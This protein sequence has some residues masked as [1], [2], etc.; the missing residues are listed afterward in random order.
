MVQQPAKNFQ[1][2]SNKIFEITD[3]P[4]E[5]NMMICYEAGISENDYGGITTNVPP[6]VSIKLKSIKTST[7]LDI[8]LEYSEIISLYNHIKS[9]KNGKQ[10]IVLNTFN[11]QVNKKLTVSVNTVKNIFYLLIIEDPKNPTPSA[12]ITLNPE[13]L[14]TFTTI[15]F[16][17]GNNWIQNTLSMNT[18]LSNHRIILELNN[19]NSNYIKTTLNKNVMNSKTPESTLK[20]EPISRVVLPNYEQTLD[21]FNYNSYLENEHV[22]EDVHEEEVTPEKKLLDSFYKFDKEEILK[23]TLK[24][25]LETVEDNNKQKEI[26]E[27]SIIFDTPSKEYVKP[28]QTTSS[29]RPFFN[30]FIEWD[31]E[32]LYKWLSAFSVVN[33][34]SKDLTFLPLEL[35]LTS[36]I[37]KDSFDEIKNSKDY[38]YFQYN[39][40]NN[41]KSGIIKYINEKDTNFNTRY[42]RFEF[43]DVN[44]ITDKNDNIHIWNFI[45]DITLLNVMYRYFLNSFKKLNIKQSSE[46][47]F[48]I[49]LA[50][51]FSTL[52]SIP[53]IKLVD[54]N[55]LPELLKDVSNLYSEV[56]VKGVFENL[57]NIFSNASMGGKFN[58]DFEGIYNYLDKFIETVGNAEITN[59][60]E[61]EIHN[62]E[63]IK[64]QFKT[65]EDSNIN[66]PDKKL[67]VFN[68]VLETELIDNTAFINLK[69]FSDIDIIGVEDP[70]IIKI[71]KLVKDSNSNIKISDI[72]RKFND[73]VEESETEVI[74]NKIEIKDP[75]EVKRE[76]FEIID[77]FSIEDTEDFDI[78]NLI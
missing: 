57:V 32:Y 70:K 34:T 58:L 35:I 17:I 6:R 28:I 13:Q 7:R 48:N 16:Q 75:V 19:L 65:S 53:L 77:M 64:N 50:E 76:S 44:K 38:Y 46:A 10:K 9:L 29:P 72:K 4:N 39:I 21:E 69:S 71:W 49:S 54:K 60:Y 59:N 3:Y 67:K 61:I 23:E 41:L 27:D 43:K 56:E 2:I 51:Y 12:Q 62:L 20:P 1:W 63:D 8:D 30:N 47:I 26:I 52:I 42:N 68:K 18:L 55:Y 24:E 66:E 14:Y 36:S 5:M 31:I 40:L 78:Y 73:D 37:G 45:V 25:E 15:L 11:K 74:I 22:E 33:E